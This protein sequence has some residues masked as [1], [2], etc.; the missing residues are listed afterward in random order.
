MQYYTI[1]QRS[2]LH[3]AALKREGIAGICNGKGDNHHR[4]NGIS[5]MKLFL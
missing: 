4:L 2:L 1:W 5:K 3:G